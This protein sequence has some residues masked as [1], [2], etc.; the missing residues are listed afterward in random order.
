MNTAYNYLTDATTSQK[1]PALHR[2]SEMNSHWDYFQAA[3]KSKVK[4]KEADLIK[5]TYCQLAISPTSNII[6]F[7]LWK[8]IPLLI[9]FVLAFFEGAIGD[10]PQL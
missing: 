5:K 9:K 1:V 4:G 2:V 10:R 8:E 7:P 3:I 6:H